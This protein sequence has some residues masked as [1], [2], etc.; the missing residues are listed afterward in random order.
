MNGALVSTTVI[1]KLPVA[2]LPLR[3]EAEQITVVVPSAN[4]DPDGGVH[5]TG[6]CPSTLSFAEAKNVTS[7]PAAPVACRVWLF[8]RPR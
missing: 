8:E 4:I 7:A 2:V 1:T 5:V 3:S 6:R